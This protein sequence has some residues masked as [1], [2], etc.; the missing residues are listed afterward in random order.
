M[1]A[2]TKRRATRKLLI[3]FGLAMLILTLPSGPGHRPAEAQ[4]V[5]TFDWSVPPRF[6]LDNNGDGIID[7][8][9]SRTTVDPSSWPVDVDACHIPAQGLLPSRFHWV[10]KRFTGDRLDFPVVGDFTRSVCTLRFNAPLLGSYLVSLA[11]TYQTFDQRFLTRS[12][13]DTIILK[14]FLIVGMGDSVGSGE[15]NPDLLAPSLDVEETWKNR[16]CHRSAN[17]GQT[18]AAKALEDIDPKTSVTFIHLACSGATIQEGIIGGDNGAEP[19][20]GTPEHCG[21]HGDGSAGCLKSQVNQALDLIGN[22]KI[23]ALLVNVGANDLGWGDIVGGCI[24]QLDCDRDTSRFDVAIPDPV[25][26][27]G[28]LNG[29]GL[30]GPLAPMCLSFASNVGILFALGGTSAQ[31]FSDRI[32]G[33][34]AEYDDL[35]AAIRNDLGLTTSSKVFIAGYF[36]PTR[37]QDG[38]FCDPGDYGVDIFRTLFGLVSKPEFAWSGTTALTGLN[39]AIRASSQEHGWTFI[40]GLPEEFRYNG[41]CAVDTKRAVRT[42]PESLEFQHDHQGMLHPNTRG[43]KFYRDKFMSYLREEFAPVGNWTFAPKLQTVGAR[44][45]TSYVLDWKHPGVW[46]DLTTLELRF[47][48]GDDIALWVR[49][50]EAEN[51]FR[52]VDSKPHRLGPAH[53]A[54]S[55]SRLQTEFATLHLS[56]SSAKGS[57]PTGPSVA[58]AFNISFK[59]RAAGQEWTAQVRATDDSRAVQQWEEAGTVIVGPIADVATK[60]N[61]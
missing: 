5:V 8:F 16:R 44:E 12:F 55:P 2:F 1:Q 14:D 22:R 13:T 51:T 29:C 30:L 61:R 52:L 42:F 23:T 6:G 59:R 25:A 4:E 46:R 40:D 31:V 32:G 3:V 56:D 37:N 57:G 41:Y 26:V 58:V 17:S 9:T 49:W 34:N 48:S 50:D 21:P 7:Y 18:L 45:A 27:L 28:I 10:I 24:L 15:G 39:N 47:R 43:H 35:N 11:I 38:T 54:G 53:E 20:F 60:H 19:P 33:L 36:D